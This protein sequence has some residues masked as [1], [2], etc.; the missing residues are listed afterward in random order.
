[1]SVA[2]FR[3]PLFLK[4]TNSP[5]HPESPDRLKAIDR[6]LNEFPS[7]DRLVDIPARDATRVDI[8]RVHDPDYFVRVE[9]T[10]NRPFSMFDLDTSACEHSYAAAIRAAGATISAVSEVLTDNHTA[11]FVFARPPGHHAEVDKAM[12]FCLFNNVAIGARY[13][14]QMTDVQRIFILDWDVHHG[15]GTSSSLK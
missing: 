2:I 4:H 6:M 13:A 8:V 7:R 14:L 10:K 9:E 3:D 1:M 11:A 12:G 15:N 5:W